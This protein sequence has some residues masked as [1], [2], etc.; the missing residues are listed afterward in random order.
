MREDDEESKIGCKWRW[1][2]EK[3]REQLEDLLARWPE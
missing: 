1:R 2:I 3:W